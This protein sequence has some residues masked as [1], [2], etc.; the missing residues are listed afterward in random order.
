MA[1]YVLITGAA[2]GFGKA[3]AAE[4][5]GR[6]WDLLIT[7]YSSEKLSLV[8]Q[9]LERQF[10][11][12]VYFFACDLTDPDSRDKLW[13]FIKQNQMRFKMLLNVAGAEFEGPF[14][15]RTLLQLRTMVRLNV[16]A[17]VENTRNI[18]LF[19][20]P[21]RP[22]RIVFV[23]SLAGFNPMPVK[24][25]YASTKRFLIN[26]T[27]ALREEFLPEEVTFT[28]VAPSGMPTTQQAIRGIC[29]Q[30]FLGRLTT[31]NVGDVAAKTIDHALA[32]KALYVPGFA[33]QLARFFSGLFPETYMA[34]IIGKRWKATYKKRQADNS[35]LIPSRYKINRY[36][37]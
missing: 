29:V 22:L 12:K 2:G 5:A 3:L 25:V 33:N 15:E 28:V 34:H 37:G 35:A 23:S 6:G 19:R 18:L 30:G 36:I 10:G 4:C 13:D 11:V 1:S 17:N 16:E 26:L 24:A 9:G 7:D 27:Y 20:D 8:A 31:K 21:I 14:A 32:G